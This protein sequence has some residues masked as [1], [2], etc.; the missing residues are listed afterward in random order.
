ML[1]KIKTF[2]KSLLPR[3]YRF[4]SSSL[5]SILGDVRRAIN[6][7]PRVRRARSL[8]RF[9]KRYGWQVQSGPFAGQLISDPGEA[10]VYGLFPNLIGSYEAELH[11][12]VEHVIESD[13]KQIVDIGAASGYYVVGFAQRMKNVHVLAFESDPQTRLLCEENVRLNG[14]AERVTVCGACTIQELNERLIAGA[15]I[16]CDCDGCEAD[17]LQ[18]E[19]VPALGAC[20]ILLELHEHIKTGTTEAILD[21]FSKTHDIE[22]IA[23]K[24]RNPADYPMLGFLSP[25]NQRIVLDERRNPE[26]DSDMLWVFMTHKSG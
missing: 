9:V 17:L 15:F 7:S 19:L 1:T 23:E 25:K 21:R 24:D 22:A 26:R 11:R 4:I 5:N 3:P 20:D 14:V 13:Y 10:H 2:L 18:P 6:P 12:I 8:A 16:L